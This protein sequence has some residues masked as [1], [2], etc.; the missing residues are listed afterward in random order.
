M[1]PKVVHKILLEMEIQIETLR[2]NKN[3]KTKGLDLKRLD[4]KIINE[5]NCTSVRQYNISKFV[6]R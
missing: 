2:I 5:D 1:H 3:L 4:L 6:M